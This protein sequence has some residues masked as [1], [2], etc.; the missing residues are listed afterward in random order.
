MHKYKN[1]A[2]YSLEKKL[3]LCSVWSNPMSNDLYVELS[4]NLISWYI[5]F[6]YS[7]YNLIIDQYTFRSIKN[8]R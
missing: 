1:Y 6:K 5:P 2:F 3:G 7:N 8:L 4:P